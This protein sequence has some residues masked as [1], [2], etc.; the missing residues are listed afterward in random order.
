MADKESQNIEFKSD[1][2]DEHLKAISAFANCMGGKLFIGLNN[3]GKPVSLKNINKLLEDIPNIIRNKL[4][5]IPTVELNKTDND[6][7]ISII[8]KPFS[9]PISYNGKFYLRSGSTVQELRGK[10]WLIF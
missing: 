7:F 1:W 2:K 5:I 4:G 3:R 8:I 9:V 6:E 10:S